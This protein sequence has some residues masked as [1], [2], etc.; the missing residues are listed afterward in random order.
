MNQ[1]Q[2]GDDRERER[3]PDAIAN[4]LVGSGQIASSLGI[5]RTTVVR[6]AHEGKLPYAHRTPAGAF[7]FRIGHLAEYLDRE[8]SQ[9]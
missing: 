9:A 5:S 1:L 4:L 3:L 7:R 6:M 2:D 8:D